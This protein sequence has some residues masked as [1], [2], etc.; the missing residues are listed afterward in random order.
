[1]LSITITYPGFQVNRD[2]DN[3]L[4]ALK[5]VDIMWFLK[6]RLEHPAKSLKDKAA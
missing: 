1:M 5:K 2:S 6:L 3:V 4:P